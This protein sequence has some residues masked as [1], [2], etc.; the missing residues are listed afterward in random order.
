MT[1][2][3]DM[4]RGSSSTVPTLTT[5]MDSTE[6]IN[7]EQ[8]DLSVSSSL[9]SKDYQCFMV[10]CSWVLIKIMLILKQKIRGIKM[11]LFTYDI[12]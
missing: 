4:E 11:S 6:K 8:L 12:H 9:K 3:G 5:D 10:F 7:K 1:E 2:E